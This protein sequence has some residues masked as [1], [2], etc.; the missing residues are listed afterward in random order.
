MPNLTY[1]D[2]VVANIQELMDFV[3]S[4]GYSIEMLSNE[5]IVDLAYEIADDEGAS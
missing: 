2:I 1:S 4:R 5:E 3:S